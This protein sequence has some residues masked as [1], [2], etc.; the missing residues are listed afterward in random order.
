MRAPRGALGNG[1]LCDTSSWV[2]NETVRRRVCCSCIYRFWFYYGLYHNRR[3]LFT[4]SSYSSILHAYVH[5]YIAR[6]EV[7]GRFMYS[8]VIRLGTQAGLQI[9]STWAR[10]RRLLYWHAGEIE[11]RDLKSGVPG[12]MGPAHFSILCA[13]VE[14]VGPDLTARACGG[15]W[16]TGPTLRHKWI[17]SSHSVPQVDPAHPN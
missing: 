14:G 3:L 2:F 5:V 12:S 7:R 8:A 16:L 13:R 1:R 17:V 9:C 10:A 6:L 15:D 11:S 4:Y